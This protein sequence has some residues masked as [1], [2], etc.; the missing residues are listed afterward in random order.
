[1]INKMTKLKCLSV[2]F[3]GLFLVVGCQ[4]QQ[5]NSQ[6]GTQQAIKSDINSGLLLG[7]A[8]DSDVNQELSAFAKKPGEYKTLWIYQ[9]GSELTCLEKPEGIITPV[10]DNL[11]KLEN[12]KF[13]LS[14]ANDTVDPANIAEEDLFSKYNFYYDTSNIVSHLAGEKAQDLYTTESFKK[15]FKIG[16]E[17]E[18]NSYQAGMEWLLFVGNKYASILDFQYQTGGGSFNSSFYDLKLCKISSLNNLENRRNSH[19]RLF[20]LLAKDEQEKLLALASKYDKIITS[21]EMYTE[22]QYLGFE[23]L[24]LKRQEGKWL[25]QAPLYISSSHSGNGSQGAYIKEFISTDINAPEILTSHDT[26]CIDWETIKQKI[27]Q[28]KDAVSSPNNDLLAVLTAEELLIYAHPSEEMEKP[29]LSIPVDED[30]RI[31]LNQWATGEDVKK[32]SELLGSVD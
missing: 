12:N 22:E 32:W 30:E 18:I 4:N 11:W 13:H 9:N 3:L 21:E 6:N 27:P 5:S 25:V 2:I 20:N 17:G 8:K 24:T 28:A 29:D 14:E 26:L 7:L 15:Q 1:M 16:V 10:K 23:K 31:I 19:V